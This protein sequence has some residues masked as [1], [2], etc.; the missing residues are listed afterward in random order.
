MSDPQDSLIAAA[1]AARA[2]AYAPY[3]H[4]SVGAA[5]LGE[6]G[7]IHAGANVENAAYPQGQCAEAS[8]IGAMILA[9]D[10][11]I[12]AIAVMGGQPGDGR[13]CT[14]CGGC[15]QRLRE[16]AKADTPIHVCGPEGLRRTFTLEE[17]LPHSFGPDNLDF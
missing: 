1:R 3:S 7:R 16:F 5:I 17:L 4:F 10:R 13:L 12:E 2:R 8:A 11:S 15:R 6:S 14:P 9:G